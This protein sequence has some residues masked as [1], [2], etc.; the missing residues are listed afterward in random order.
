MMPVTDENLLATWKAPDL[1]AHKL[2]LIDWS[3]LIQT[4]EIDK[5]VLKLWR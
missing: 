5:E 3:D 1:S 4:P 2:S